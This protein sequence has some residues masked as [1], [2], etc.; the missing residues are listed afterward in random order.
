MIGLAM[1][2]GPELRY[3]AGLLRKAAVKDLKAELRKGQ[4]K[5]FTPLQKEIKLEAAAALPGMYAGVMAKAVKVSVRTG[6]ARTVFTVRIY[7]RGKVELRDVRSINA[8]RIRH[9][10]FGNRRRWYTTQV[11]PGFVDRPVDR[12]WD[13]VVDE[14]ADAV[15]RVLLQIAKG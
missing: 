5:A 14:S 2:G 9:P 6:F 1:T 11:R 10:L 15:G 13:R 7:A 4:R 12:N 8:G 3:V